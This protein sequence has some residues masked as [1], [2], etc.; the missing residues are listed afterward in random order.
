MGSIDLRLGPY[1]SCVLAIAVPLGFIGILAIIAAI[2]YLG[3]SFWSSR[4]W[5]ILVVLWVGSLVHLG[6]LLWVIHKRVSIQRLPG[7]KQWRLVA[8][9]AVVELFL[10][11]WL[12]WFM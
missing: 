3:S 1:L 12:L 5:T 6:A 2:G 10:V 9:V 4:D 7:A 11:W 8:I